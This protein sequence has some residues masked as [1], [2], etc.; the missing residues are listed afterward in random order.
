MKRIITL[1]LLVLILTAAFG[2]VAHAANYVYIHSDVTRVAANSSTSHNYSVYWEY[3]S[4]GASTSSSMRSSGCRVVAHSKLLAEAGIASKTT[5]VFNPDIYFNWAVANGFFSSGCYEN[6]SVGAGL[7]R[8]ASDRGVSV[9][10]SE[11]SL[12]G[13]NSASDISTVMSK[14][15]EGYYVILSCSA[16]QAYV[17]RAASLNAGTPVILDSWSNWSYTPYQVQ[18][19]NG[20]T[21]VYFTKAHLFRVGNVPDPTPAPTPVF[22][23]TDDTTDQ[24]RRTIGETTATMASTISVTNASINSVTSVGINLYDANGTY[25]ASGS[26]TPPTPKNGVINAWYNIYPGSSDVNYTLS[27]GRTYMYRFWAKIGNDTYFDD[28]K[29]FAT[30]GTNPVISVTLSPASMNLT[31]GNTGAITATVNP[32]DATY[33]TLTWTSN[34]PSV[35]TVNDYGYVTPV[36]P[37]TAVITATASNGVYGT[38]TVTVQPVYVSGVTLSP[39]TLSL[40]HHGSSYTLSATV[41]PSNATNKALSWA[42]DAPSVATVNSSG[43]VTPVAPG[44]ATITAT[45]TDGSGKSGTCSVTVVN[46]LVT[47]VAID[48]ETLNLI[49]MGS[50][51]TL[52]TTVLPGD[53]TDKTLS[54][55]SSDP[56]VATVNN[57]TV[58]PLAAGETTIT[59]TAVD[60]SGK[61]DSCLVTVYPGVDDLTLNPYSVKLATEGIGRQYQIQPIVTPADAV[62]DIEFSSS[63]TSVAT[64]SDGGMITAVG[65]GTATIDILIPYGPETSMAVSVQDMNLFTLPKGLVEI[66]SEAFRGD[67][68]ERVVMSSDV[69]RIG[70]YAFADNRNLRFV[71]IPNSVVYIA[72]NA[73]SG[74]P[75]VCLLYGGSGYVRTWAA[76][77]GVRCQYDEDAATVKVKSIRVPNDLTMEIDNEISLSAIVSPVTATNKTLVWSSSNPAVAEITG[78]GM[79]TTLS[80]G[81]TTITAAATDGSGVSASF[82]LTVVLPNISVE[83]TPNAEATTI[84]DDDATLSTVITVA[85]VEP[86]KIQRTGIILMNSN[87]QALAVAEDE[88]AVTGNSIPCSFSAFEDFGMTLS[89]STTYKYRFYTVIYDTMHESETYSFTTDAAVTSISLPVSELTI[90]LDETYTLIPKIKYAQSDMILWSTSKSSVVRVSN[91]V[92]TPI[93]VGTATITA[94]L[95]DDTSLYATCAV[96]VQEGIPDA[97]PVT[98]FNFN[99]RSRTMT[100]GDQYTLSVS[101]LPENATDRSFSLASTNTAVATVSPD[102]VI[103]AVGPGEAMIVA[104]AN[105]G[106]GVSDVCEVEVNA[107]INV[108]YTTYTPKQSIGSTNAVLAS[109]I[110]VSGASVDNVTY[111]GLY[112]YNAQGVLLANKQE[113]PLPKDGVINAWYDI[114]S[115]LNYTLTAGTT[116][117]YRFMSVINGKQYYSNYMTFTT[118]AAASVINVSFTSNDHQS[119]GTMTPTVAR[120][121]SVSGNATISDVSY[122][123]CYL[124]NAAGGQLAYKREVPKPLNGVINAWYGI[125]DELGCTLSAGTTYQYRFVAVVNGVDYFSAMDS[126]T[127]PAPSNDIQ[128]TY[129]SNSH[130]SIGSVNA[131][132]ARTISVSGADISAVTE[133]GCYLYNNSGT[134]LGSKREAPTPLNG[135]INAWYDVKNEL[136]VT[137]VPNTTYKYRFVAV[138]NQVDYYSDYATFTLVTATPNNAKIQAVIDRAYDWVNYTWTAPVD[139]PVYNNVYNNS[140]YSAYYQKEYYFKAGTVMHGLPYTLSNSKYNLETYAALSNSNKATATTFTYSGVLMWG[141]KYGADCSGLVNDVLY[142]GDPAIGHDGQTYFTSSK[143]Y[144]YEAI[145]WDDVQPGDALG[146]TGHTMIVVG[147]SGNNITTIEQCGNGSNSGALHCTNVTV[148]PAGGYYV[149][150]TCSAC[151]G[152]NKGATVLRTRTKSQLSQYTVYRYKKLY[153]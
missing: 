44:T 39:A 85:G 81:Q 4:Q 126:F 117:Q 88:P 78:D 145:S 41:L 115:E 82:K 153:E 151:A 116:Y 110:S 120:T 99:S 75:N 140:S 60:G 13:S 132:V 70:E 100:V 103:T 31:L 8:Y 10:H 45:A 6:T 121:I 112:L 26:D 133:V 105:D 96:T 77:N 149:C 102:G 150:G 94:R 27:P 143:A 114:N 46:K 16:H 28:L 56:S 104:S 24:S 2:S 67:T 30:Q 73:F 40:T 87:G 19:Y 148:R 33:K 63:N 55:D 36:A 20:Y 130:Q 68:M 18:Q 59:A 7:I 23:F 83:Y 34:T 122:V 66:E 131:T 118:S 142:Y 89:P 137:P 53:A 57:G 95:A 108:S 128:V 147:V 22:S 125:T 123:G 9:S 80:V 136:G 48:E 144:L 107:V 37:G 98:G 65:P 54:W 127:T 51:A 5:S 91:G 93:S 52:T 43:V 84:R 69:E 119:L 35:A 29:S 109:T 113:V 58:T 14:I 49:A 21:Q 11:I 38:C 62:Y 47:S 61:S 50:S 124:Y 139:I 152:A 25:I 15:N 135:V 71:L 86:S 111:V 17:G 146:I 32:S 79:F 92:L 106:S 3:W 129:T 64:V 134:P 42:S 101:A 90:S 138:V 74:C 12:S 1:A 72:D 141:P 97:I 76:D